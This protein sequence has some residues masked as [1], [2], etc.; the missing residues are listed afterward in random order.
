MTIFTRSFFIQATWNYK[1]MISQGFTFCILPALTII[2]R[3]KTD[4]QKALLKHL[5][6]FNTH[7]FF[8]SYVLGAAIKIEEHHSVESINEYKIKLGNVLGSLGDRF[9]WKFLKPFSVI[10]GITVLLL[11]KQ[12]FPYNVITGIGFFLLLFNCP[13]VYFRYKGL[14]EG[15]KWGYNI[16]QHLPVAAINKMN[17]IIMITG[18]IFLGLL[19]ALEF[20]FY[21]N[22]EME[23][24]MIFFISALISFT[25]NYRKTLINYSLVIPLAAIFIILILI[26]IIKI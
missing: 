19:C 16:S 14:K 6:F 17:H 2:Y 25:L 8:S 4:M 12:I 11:L 7:P 20:K 1:W 24:I 3:K 26:D 18:M 15:Y 21:L 5:E 22:F 23:K 9:F 10:T 13:V